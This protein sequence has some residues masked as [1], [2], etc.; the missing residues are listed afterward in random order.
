MQDWHKEGLIF[1]PNQ[2]SYWQKSHAALPTCLH[3]EGDFYRIYFTSRD[4]ENKTYVGWFVI[5]LKFPHQI[6][7]QS[8]DPVLSPG[9]LGFFD[10]HGVQATSVVR[11]GNDVYLYY[12]GWNPGLAQPVF[13]TAIGLAISK[14]GGRTFQKYSDAPIME[15]S[16]FDPWMVSGGTVRKEDER[17]RMWYLSGMKFEMNE[18]VASSYYDLKYAESTDGIHWNREGITAIPLLVGETNISRISIVEKQ[19]KYFGWYPVKQEGSHYRI[20]FSVSSDG[21][22]WQRRDGDLMLHVSSEGWD[23]QALDKVEVISHRGK[24]F[25][26]YNGNRF[27]Y[28]GI[29]LAIADDRL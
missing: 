1:R 16:R 29:G 4:A 8:H 21:I 24:L 5:D 11:N 2:V 13:Y 10:D 18:G 15:R 7:E 17:W 20:G 22:K 27:G 23:N 14:D 25:M 19:G 6:L 28:D 3:L 26:F 9:P 12:L